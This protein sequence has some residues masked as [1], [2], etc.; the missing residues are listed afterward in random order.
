MDHICTC[1]RPLR[2]WESFNHFHLLVPYDSVVQWILSLFAFVSYSNGNKAK[3]DLTY[4]V[5]NCSID[6]PNVMDT[7]FPHCPILDIKSEPI[8]SY[9]LIFSNTYM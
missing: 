1:E 8:V 7:Y 6:K 2:Y 5:H 3:K 9:P 4:M